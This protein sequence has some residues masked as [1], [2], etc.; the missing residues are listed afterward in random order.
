[1]HMLHESNI[2][3]RSNEQPVTLATDAGPIVPVEK[4]I[5]IGAD[6][7]TKETDDVKMQSDSV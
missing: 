6:A 3:A 2:T 4:P 1:M 5:A 7:K